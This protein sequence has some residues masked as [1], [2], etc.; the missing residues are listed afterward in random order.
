MPRITCPELCPY[1]HLHRAS[2][3]SETAVAVAHDREAPW[4][5]P[6][7]SCKS[8]FLTIWSSSSRERTRRP[9]CRRRT[10]PTKA[11]KLRRTGPVP[12]DHPPPPDKVSCQKGLFCPVT[13]PPQQCLNAINPN[14]DIRA[15][16]WRRVCNRE[17]GAAEVAERPYKP[18]TTVSLALVSG[19]SRF[20]D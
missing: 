3:D 20:R 10:P 9:C 7:G 2:V 17:Q 14:P 11:A 15:M 19:D 13:N 6:R 4:V 18:P 8:P 5:W 1:L 12:G 16:P